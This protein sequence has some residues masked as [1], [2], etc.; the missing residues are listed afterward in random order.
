MYSSLKKY[1]IWNKSNLNEISK[2][3]KLKHSLIKRTIQKF[4]GLK[5]RQQIIFKKKFLTIINDSKSTSFSKQNV[6]L[7]RGLRTIKSGTPGCRRILVAINCNQM[8]SSSKTCV[9]LRGLRPFSAQSRR[10]TINV[11]NWTIKAARPTLV[12]R[13]PKI[14][15]AAPT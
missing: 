1:N 10:G 13:R 15:A 4:N 2:K 5:Y 7:T 6:S 11:V 8:Y 3:F 14:C 12:N 9:G